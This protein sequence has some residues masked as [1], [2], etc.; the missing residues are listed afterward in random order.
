MMTNN[1]NFDK[2]EL[3]ILYTAVNFL[4]HCQSPFL[5]GKKQELIL[6]KINNQAATLKGVESGLLAA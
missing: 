3:L 1:D 2:E 6:R 5:D 4:A